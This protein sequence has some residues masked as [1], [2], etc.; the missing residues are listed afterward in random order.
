MTT[1]DKNNE[2][3]DKIQDK[4]DFYKVGHLAVRVLKKANELSKADSLIT[5]LPMGWEDLDKQTSGLNP[6]DLV[7]V[8]GRPMMGKTI[9]CLNIATNVALKSKKNVAFFSLEMGSRELVTRLLS[10]LGKIDYGKI[11]RGKLLNYEYQR[12]ITPYL[13]LKE[14]PLYIN[15]TRGLTPSE[16]YE[17]C[18]RLARDLGGLGLIIVDCLQLMEVK[19]SNENRENQ[20]TEIT[21][22]LKILAKEFDCPVIAVS[23][24][25]RSLEQRPNKRP[26]LSDLRGSDAIEDIA[27]IVM[28]IYRG[29]VY[30]SDENPEKKNDRTA[31][32]IIGKQRNGPIG[33]VKLTFMGEYTKFVDYAAMPDDSVHFG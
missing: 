5:G 8:A 16:L 22:L 21:R 12:L 7:V 29:A 27:D 28:F 25:N 15:D 6:G 20:L 1:N 24:L 23:Q 33:T 14:A 30:A 26:I 11:Y 19:D 3:D 17:K 9:F 2:L 13:L 31:E 18:Q 4:D 32:I 10:A